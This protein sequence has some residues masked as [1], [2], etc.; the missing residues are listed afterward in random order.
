MIDNKEQFKKII[1]ESKKNSKRQSKRELDRSVVDWQLFYLNNLDIFTE[2]YLE[3]PLHHFQRQLL[4]DCAYYDIMDVIASRGLS[5][6]FCIGILATDLALLLPGVNI[7]ITS[8]TLGQSNKIINEK[9][10]VLLS[11]EIKGISRVLKQLR[12]D[13]YIQFKKDDTGEARIVDFGNGSKIFAVCCGEG[14]RSNRSNITITDEAALVSKTDYERI[15]EPTLEPYSFNGLYLE[16]K[17]IF[18]TSARTKDNW[19][20]NHLRTTVNSHYKDK[21]IKYGFFAGDIFTAVANKVQTKN[22][23][24]TRKKNTD[25][26]S[27]DMEFLNLWLGESK[28]SIFKY[29]D[30]HKAQVLKSPFYPLSTIEY[31]DKKENE[32]K[33]NDA[34]IR[35]L[36]VDIAVSGGRD[37]DN[38][39]YL[40]GS[41]NKETAHKKSEYILSKNGLNSNIQ[42]VIMKRLFYDY[43]CDYIV[44]DSKGVGNVIYDMLT[45]ETYD[46][47]R[48]VTYPAWTV[49]RDKSLQVSSDKVISDKI[50]RTMTNDAKEVIIPFAGTGELNTAIHLSARK[51]LRDG[52]VDLLKDD[53]EMELILSEKRKD[54]IT[55]SSEEKTKLLLP[56][57]ETR[58]MINE[59]VTLNVN[60]KADAI[61]VKED[62]SATKDRYMTFAMFNYFGDKLINK[63]SKDDNNENYNESDWAFL[64]GDFSNCNAFLNY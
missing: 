59:A 53:S 34:D 49:C 4:N 38:T 37:N 57:L 62:R 23:Y 21:N 15:I 9:I 28:D 19:M 63:L 5:K 14:G 6:S 31:M 22:Q 7:L 40:L 36:T 51:A 13:K 47:E 30:F 11:S 24:I 42:V 61:T 43:K 16:P 8:K 48:N 2:E 58:F 52:T 32:Y 45:V 18:L 29:D 20:W 3:I 39:I 10:D 56:F 55:L 25:P 60:I 35:Y 44:I 1:A 26:I 54:W 27:F 33:F 50:E 41:V 17:Q 12:R 46:E 64:S